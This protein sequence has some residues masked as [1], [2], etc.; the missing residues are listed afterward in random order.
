MTL[1]LAKK[2]SSR[3]VPTVEEPEA[4]DVTFSLTTDMQRN[5]DFNVSLKITN[6]A[7]SSRT[8]DVHMSA[9]SCRYTGISNADLKDACTTDVLEPNAGICI[10]RHVF[11]VNLSCILITHCD[12]CLFLFELFVFSGIVLDTKIIYTLKEK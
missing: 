3:H 7:S 11:A 10:H 8:V 12:H 9:I 5:G 2:L 6:T 1:E 4:N